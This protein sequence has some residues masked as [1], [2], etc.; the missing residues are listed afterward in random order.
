MVFLNPVQKKNPSHVPGWKVC[1]G[2]RGHGFGLWVVS[3]IFLQPLITETPLFTLITPICDGYQ[4]NHLRRPRNVK[5]P[6]P[7]VC[8]IRV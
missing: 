8:R 1:F 5:R 2:A 3:E 6:V 4:K 7:V